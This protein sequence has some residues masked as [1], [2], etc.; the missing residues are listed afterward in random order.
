MEKAV[1]N[2]PSIIVEAIITNIHIRDILPNSAGGKSFVYSARM[3]KLVSALIA[4]DKEKKL[5]AFAK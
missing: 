2:L 5:K 1:F 4:C 3:P